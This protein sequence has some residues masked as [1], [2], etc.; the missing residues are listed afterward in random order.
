MSCT[1]NRFQILSHSIDKKY[2]ENKNW[3]RETFFDLRKKLYNQGKLKFINLNS[4]TVFVIESHVTESNEYFGMIWNKTKSLSY[5]YYKNNFSF[6]NKKIFTDYTV[7]LVQKWDTINI[8]LEEKVNGN[9]IPENYIYACKLIV[10]N[11]II[12]VNNISFKE[13]FDLK[14]DR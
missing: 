11:N 10:S 12:T 5:M 13:F 14:R 2:Q 8:R 6:E 4:D 7:K 9:L 3:K 1:P